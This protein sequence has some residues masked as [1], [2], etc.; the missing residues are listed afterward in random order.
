MSKRIISVLT[1]ILIVTSAA[2]GATRMSP[3]DSIRHKLPQLSGAKKLLALKNLCELAFNEDN[4]NYELRCLNDY[5]EEAHRQNSID[6]EAYGM[7]SRLFCYYNYGMRKQMH[8]TLPVNLKFYEAHGRWKDYYEDWSETIQSDIFNGKCYTALREVNEMYSDARKRNDSYGLGTASFAIGDA[9]LGLGKTKEAAKA[10]EEA[11]QHLRGHYDSSTLYDTY[12]CYCD[13]LNDMKQYAKL[14]KTAQEWGNTLDAYR[15]MAKKKGWD[16]SMLDSRYLYCYIAK[17]QAA[18]GMGDLELADKMLKMS[19]KIANGQKPIAHLSLLLEQSRYCILKKDYKKALEYNTEGMKLNIAAGDTLGLLNRKEQRANIL[20]QIGRPA[21]AAELYHEVMQKRDSINTANTNNQ[22]NELSTLYGLDEMKIEKRSTMYLLYGST[23]CILLLIAI[24]ILYI[25]HS[26]K[27]R[28]KNRKLYEAIV[29]KQ[30]EEKEEKKNN[31]SPQTETSSERILFNQLCEL[32]E[33]EEPWKDNQINRDDLAR[34]LGTN[35]TY[36]ADAIKKFSDG[37]TITE[38]INHY[39]LLHAAKMLSEKRDLSI[40]EIG[41][42]SG[43]NS[44]STFNRLFR[45]YYGMSPS[46]FRTAS[47]TAASA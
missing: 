7:S 32:L 22:L 46:E 30:K 36:L 12:S 18:M 2:C 40:T 24:L 44:R 10:F 5:I 14:K 8:E 17:A 3:S 37:K 4:A 45:D 21:E 16:F 42:N 39:R 19:E 35:R 28:K 6:D 47:K 31:I 38:F 13:M 43:F 1:I 34:K 15:I 26:N 23:V 29:E 11:L 20:M 33:T 9:Y 41:E 27:L 25:A